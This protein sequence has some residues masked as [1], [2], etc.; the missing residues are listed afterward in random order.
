ML[1]LNMCE[2]EDLKINHTEEQLFSVLHSFTFL[3][4][5]SVLQAV[6]A[7]NFSVFD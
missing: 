1:L 3:P 2:A 6:K 5:H 7:F 4:F